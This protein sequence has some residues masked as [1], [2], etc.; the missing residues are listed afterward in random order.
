MADRVS[1]VYVII[2][3]K[4]IYITYCYNHIPMTLKPIYTL[5]FCFLLTYQILGQTSPIPLQEELTNLGIDSLH[6]IKNA[7]SRAGKSKQLIPVLLVL[8]EKIRAA[9]GSQSAAYVDIVSGLSFTYE[10]LADFEK[11]NLYYEQTLHLLKETQGTSSPMYIVNLSYYGDFLK[12]K[13]DYKAAEAILKK[14]FVLGQQNKDKFTDL[15]EFCA[16][17]GFL[18]N[19]YRDRQQY[20]EALPLYLEQ[21]KIYQEQIGNQ[22]TEYGAVLSNLAAVY[23]RIGHYDKTLALEQES[24][25]VTEKYHGVDNFAYGQRINNLAL[26]YSALED[27]ETADSLFD[28]A[29]SNA[30][31]ILGKD[32]YEYALRMQNLGVNYLYL[33]Q[34][35]EALAMIEKARAIISQQLPKNHVQHINNSYFYA[36]VLALNQHPKKAVEVLEEAVTPEDDSKDSSQNQLGL[37]HFRDAGWILEG[38]A[39]DSIVEAYYLGSNSQQLQR[40]HHQFEYFSEQE[41]LRYLRMLEKVNDRF[42]SYTYRHQEQVHLI[43]HCLNN[44]LASNGLILRNKQR[45]LRAMRIAGNATLQSRFAQWTQLKRKLAQSYGQTQNRTTDIQILQAEVEELEGELSRASVSFKEALQPTRWEEISQH[46]QEGEVAIEFSAFRYYPHH[47]YEASDSTFYVAFLVRR[48][49]L[50][51]KMVFLFEE[52][53]LGELAHIRAFYRADTSYTANLYHLIWKRLAGELQG[54]HSIYYSPT[55]L[56]HQVNFGAIPVGKNETLADRFQLYRMSSTRQVIFRDTNSRQYEMKAAL[57]GD[58]DYDHFDENKERHRPSGS[59]AV[60]SPKVLQSLANL[61]RSSAEQSWTELPWSAQ[62][63]QQIHETL[64]SAGIKADIYTERGASESAFKRLSDL[65]PS[66]RILHLAT[67]GYFFPTP[68]GKAKLGFQRASHPL[69]RSGL[70]LAGANQVWKEKQQPKGEDGILTAYEIAEL[71][72][73]QTELVV[74]SACDT[75]LGDIEGNE[76]VFGLQRAFKLAGAK[77]IIMSLWNVK[78]RQSME[79]MRLFYKEWLEEEQDIP[80]AFQVAQNKLRAK[81]AKPW[82]PFLWAGFVLLE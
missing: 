82:S 72:L 66:P 21:L 30:A 61:E 17:Y 35:P 16:T 7:L 51:P 59:K 31:E 63:V 11:A 22:H 46:L 79:F 47:N 55:A 65:A 77:Y 2:L 32:H 71:D 29:L 15:S 44:R 52:K 80:K 1:T 68:E 75:G 36:Q 73:S 62:E 53:E 43:S 48:D 74:L 70:I 64:R 42:A 45:L 12:N 67:H 20:T 18:G 57:F 50:H 28:I 56:L 26:S 6:Q 13:G 58:I 19:Y 5:A 49:D 3:Q 25:R 33:Q 39:Q 38:G 27:Y 10:A 40:L 60:Q 78:D 4:P 9:H 76:G 54:V 69:I 41:Q 34:Y 37:S 24:V 8:E 14:A 81:Y 23:Q